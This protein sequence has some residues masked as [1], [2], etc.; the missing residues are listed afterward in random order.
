[1]TSQKEQCTVYTMETIADEF[2]KGEYKRKSSST[3]YKA[4]AKKTKDARINLRLQED[5]LIYFQELS[6]KEGIPYQTL[7]NSALF[8][9]ASGQMVEKKFSDLG[10][11]IEELKEQI[12]EIQFKKE[13]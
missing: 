13:A 5:V 11:Q 3:D 1:M 2:A 6:S 12:S 7:I 4:I 8:K 9:I 10:K